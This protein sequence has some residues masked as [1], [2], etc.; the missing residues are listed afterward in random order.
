MTYAFGASMRINR[1]V[2]GLIGAVLDVFGNL[3]RP[4]GLPGPQPR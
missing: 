4:V 3:G 2:F 1:P